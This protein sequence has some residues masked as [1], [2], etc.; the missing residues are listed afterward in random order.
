MCTLAYLKFLYR[1][2]L[3]QLRPDVCTHP[4]VQ[5]ERIAIILGDQYK[6]EEGGLR[7][8]L[9]LPFYSLRVRDI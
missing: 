6:I 2:F 9:L 7:V 8:R 3:I 4:Q 1:I 5:V